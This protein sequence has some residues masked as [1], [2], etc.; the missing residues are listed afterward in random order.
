MGKGKHNVTPPI[1]TRVI[2]TELISGLGTLSAGSLTIPI[3]LDPTLTSVTMSEADRFTQYRFTKVKLRLYAPSAL[4]QTVTEAIDV[5]VCYVPTGTDTPPSSSASAARCAQHITN[6]VHVAGSGS[7]A[8]QSYPYTTSVQ[9]MILEREV[10]IG[11]EA[12]KWWKTEDSANVQTY[13]ETQG[14]LYIVLDSTAASSTVVQYALEVEAHAEFAGNVS[15]AV[16]PLD[17]ALMKHPNHRIARLG[18]PPT[19]KLLSDKP[20]PSEDLTM[21]V[22]AD[23]VK[24]HRRGT[25]VANPPS[26]S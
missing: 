1:I 9:T 6:G 23:F 22:L 7:V 4:S 11:Q 13:L 26:M 10:L 18:N 8:Q 20:F 16:T 12:V 5:V 21:S 25:A 2:G 17:E 15:T 19:G 14:D 3:V 24:V